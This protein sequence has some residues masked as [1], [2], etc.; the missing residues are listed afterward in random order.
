MTDPRVLHALAALWSLQRARAYLAEHR[1]TIVIRRP[2]LGPART[3]PR[4]LAQL[5][6]HDTLL[7][8]ERPDRYALAGA[9][10][11]TGP[12]PVAPGLLDLDL[13]IRQ[14]LVDV[15]ELLAHVHRTHRLMSHSPH[16]DLHAG[17]WT[18]LVAA[19][20]TAPP[21]V[22]QEIRA[23]VEPVDGRARA[24]AGVGPD[25]ASHPDNPRCPACRCRLVRVQTSAPDPHH[26]TA[27]CTTPTCWCLGPGDPAGG[28][29]CPC[30]MPVRVAG[31]RHI[32]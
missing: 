14:V 22:A 30:T 10:M 16:W 27:I 11:A 17:R 15:H 5:A 9:K 23:L 3:R 19:C 32:W 28:D 13:D 7:R 2:Q 20:S 24:I 31:E 25:R 1:E 18:W 8:T 29:G 21:G 12:A 4:S 6:A 26:W